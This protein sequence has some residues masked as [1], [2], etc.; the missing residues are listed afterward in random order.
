M[1]KE[2]EII[3]GICG[4]YAMKRG[5]PSPIALALSLSL[6]AILL[7][8]RESLREVPGVRHVALRRE[9]IYGYGPPFGSTNGVI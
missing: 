7:G 2:E 8:A 9:F 5:A 1:E 6:S 3:R 4:D